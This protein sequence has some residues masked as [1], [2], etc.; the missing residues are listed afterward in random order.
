MSALLWI[1][2]LAG[3]MAPELG[4]ASIPPATTQESNGAG[5][6][7]T[8]R[9]ELRKDGGPGHGADQPYSVR[10]AGARDLERFLGGK[11]VV[12]VDP[13]DWLFLIFL[14]VLIVVLVIVL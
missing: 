3:S 6:P 12:F 13:F 8:E 9:L 4:P 14:V 10:E 11:Q 1:V 7:S 5:A 2:L